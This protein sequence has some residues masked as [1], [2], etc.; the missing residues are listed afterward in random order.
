MFDDDN[1]I[2]HEELYEEEDDDDD[3]ICEV[4]GLYSCDCDG[5]EFDEDEY[6]D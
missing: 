6:L 5:F 1:V 3:G 2:E 4:C